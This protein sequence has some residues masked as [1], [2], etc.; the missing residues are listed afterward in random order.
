MV[1]EAPALLSL[2]AP[3]SRRPHS[4]APRRPSA[5]SLTHALPVIEDFVLLFLLA[6]LA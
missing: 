1:T 3:A 2:G 6:L 5:V 4:L